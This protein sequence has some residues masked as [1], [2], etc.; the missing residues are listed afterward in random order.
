MDAGEYLGVV[1]WAGFGSAINAFVT[2]SA[3]CEV[4]GFLKAQTSGH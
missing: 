1:M 4:P 2:S 3:G